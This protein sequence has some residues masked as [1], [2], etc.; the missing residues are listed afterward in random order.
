MKTTSNDQSDGMKEKNGLPDTDTDQ[1]TTPEASEG[2]WHPNEIYLSS[3][4]ELKAI[5]LAMDWE[6]NDQ[7]L[8]KLID[9]SEKLMNS[10]EGDLVLMAY[11]KM[12]ASLGKYIKARKANSDKD[13]LGLLS[14][15]Y[16]GMEKV[17][18]TDEM[19]Y[20]ERERL[21]IDE[22][23]KFQVLKQKIA[24]PKAGHSPEK[25]LDQTASDAEINDIKAD[26]ASLHQD[27]N[28]LREQI[29]RVLEALDR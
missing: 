21:V 25:Q 24:G 11:F 23:N 29:T 4:Q 10:S 1:E 14:S 18:A 13:A 27:V 26:V 15:V 12:L 6:I 20:Q 2:K 28:E 7:T 19:P 8:N 17:I 16:E 22:I 5:F 9:E 3:L